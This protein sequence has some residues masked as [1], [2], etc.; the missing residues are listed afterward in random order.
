MNPI[1]APSYGVVRM[2]GGLRRRESGLS[3]NRQKTR[4]KKGK[5]VEIPVPTRGTSTASLGRSLVQEKVVDALTR[6]TG[7]LSDPADRNARRPRRF[8]VSL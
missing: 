2:G 7:L 3:G 1:A 6:K 4:P 5:P 8:A